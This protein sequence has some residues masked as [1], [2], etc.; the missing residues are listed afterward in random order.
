MRKSDEIKRRIRITDIIQPR[1]GKKGGFVC[2]ICGSGEQ[3][4]GAFHIYEDTNTFHCFSCGAGSSVI[5]L[6]MLLHD[7]KKDSKEDFEKAVAELSETA[8][9]DWKAPLPPSRPLPSLEAK[10]EK[11]YTQYY[12]D[13]RDRLFAIDNSGW[14]GLEYIEKRGLD[15]E[16]CCNYFVGFDPEADPAGAGFKTPRL[17]IPTTKSH[18]IGR[19]IYDDRVER[20][21]RKMNSAGASAGFFNIKTL[22]KQDTQEVFICEAAIDALSFLTVGAQ[23]IGLNSADNVPKFIKALEADR[24]R[25]SITFIIALDNDE[26][27]RTKGAELAAGLRRLGLS[28]IMAGDIYGEHKDANEALCADREAFSAAVEGAKVDTAARPDNTFSYIDEFMAEDMQHFNRE[29]K[30]GFQ[31]FDKITGGLYPALYVLAAISSLGKTSYALQMADQLAERGEDVLFFSLEMSRLELVS[32]SLARTEA[33]LH[34]DKIIT[35]TMIRKGAEVPDAVK[36][37]KETV[38]RRL[39]IVEGNF[40]ANISFI[41]EYIRKY[42]EKTGTRPVVFIDYLQILQPATEDARKGKREAIDNTVSELKRLSRELDA[43]IVVISSVNRAN[44]QAPV[45]FESLKESGNIEYSADVVLG[46][47][48]Q[49]LNESL[50]ESETKTVE[51]RERVMKEKQAN[52]R[53]IELVALKNRFGVSSF[54]CYY[55]YYPGKDLFIETEDAG[56]EAPAPMPRKWKKAGEK[57][58]P[59]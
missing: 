29:R 17:I 53:K 4:D 19:A 58:I 44:Y 5:D 23:A 28:F 43:P 26:A 46:L 36:K 40:D 35:S 24:P 45:C 33:Q 31:N 3:G 12:K 34:P 11:D 39:S 47:Q 9:I 37:Y 49:C 22:K 41:G 48:L 8:G 54:S 25:Q 18:Y 13:C 30:T 15:L 14:P 51:K 32:K 27:G 52:P 57:D 20:K 7:M 2:P 10:E 38:G 6:Y 56:E 42:M 21:Y 59:L 1:K 16:V 55:N 50:F